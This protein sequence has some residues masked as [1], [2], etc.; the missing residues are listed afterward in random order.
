LGAGRRGV[1]FTGVYDPTM[2]KTFS[3][4]R[5]IPGREDYKWRRTGRR[6]LIAT[7]LALE[8]KDRKPQWH[9]PKD[10]ARTIPFGFGNTTEPPLVIDQPATGRVSPAKLVGAG[11]PQ[12]I[13][14]MFSGPDERKLLPRQAVFISPPL[15]W[16]RNRTTMDVRFFNPN[17]GT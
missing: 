7:L 10:D 12:W 2:R 4:N 9:T 17:P 14:S 11:K 5:G 15:T 6:T 1:G 16:A 13:F 3:C 8:P